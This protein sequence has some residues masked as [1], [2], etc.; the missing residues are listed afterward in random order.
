MK[1]LLVLIFTLPLVIFSQ[2]KIEVKGKVSD[3]ENPIPFANISIS[4]SS[5]GTASDLDG[6]YQLQ[7][8]SGI[9]TIQVQ[10]VGFRTFQ[11]K[12]NSEDYNSFRILS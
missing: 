8:P 6:N 9:Y 11:Q 4:N 5:V 12:I 3:G 2:E 7:L 10:A 1:N